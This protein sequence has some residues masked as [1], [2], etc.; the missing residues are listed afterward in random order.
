[1]ATASMP[2][3]D[4]ERAQTGSGSSPDGR[5]KLSNR[6]SS[7]WRVLEGAKKLERSY[8]EFD[9]RNASQ[10]HLV[11]ADGDT[12]KNKVISLAFRFMPSS[13]PGSCFVGPVSLLQT[14][15]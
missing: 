8:D 2:H 6:T 7:G 14:R 1:M 4:A 10:D 11:Y 12:P 15:N 9:T 3:Y 13:P 5:P